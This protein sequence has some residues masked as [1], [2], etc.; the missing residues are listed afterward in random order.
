MTRILLKVAGVLAGLAVCVAL[1]VGL[2]LALAYPNL[3]DLD[4]LTDY[5][6]KVPLRVYTADNVLIGEFG[7]ER[8]NVVRIRDVPDVLKS[9]ILSAEDDGFYQHG[10]IDWTGVLRAA[11]TNAI[12]LQK[13]Q[14]ASTI[15]MQVARNFYLSSEKTYTRKLYEILLTFKIEANL[16]KD[17]I[18]ELYIN[19]IYLGQ[20]AYG[21]AS[22]ARIYFGK[23][24]AELT[25]SEAAMLAGIP[26][27]PS[28][29]NPVV[30]PTRATLR[31]QYVLRRM[32]ELGYLTD[33]EYRAALDDKMKI[34]PLGGEFAV[35][36]EYVAELA[37]QLVYDIYKEDTYT[38]G[39]NVYT[40]VN[41]A[42]QDAAY[43]ALRDGVM[44]YERRHGYRGPEAFVELPDG[45]DRDAEKLNE[46]VDDALTDH[47]DNDDLLA[48]VV[49]SADANKV[50]VARSAGEII[51][52]TGKGLRFAASGL[53][54]KAQPTQ[55]V[56]RGA[57][58]RIMKTGGE[59][60]ILQ[61]PAV[62][63]AFVSTDP[64]D[65][66]IR[67]M[68][69]G[70]D[71]QRG[72]FNRVTQAWR[73]PGSSFKPFIYAASL[74]RGLTPSTIISDAPFVLEA[75][76]TGS[77]RWE[78]KNYDGKNEAPM[79]MRQGLAKSKNLVSIRILQTIGPQYAQDYIT[80]FGFEAA[81]HPAYLTMA[82]GAGAVTPLQMA[83]AYSV[84]ANGGYRV[85]PFLIDKV[86]DGSGRVL[87][88]A[89]PAKA[90]DESV[91]AIDA[92][93]AYITDTMLRDVVRTG[94]ARAALALKRTDVGGKTGTTNNSV[95]GWFAGYTPQLVGIAWLG[96]DQPKSLGVRETGG[97]A[98]MP[99]WLAYMQK[100]LKGVPQQEQVMPPGIITANGDYYLSEFPPGQ[101]VATVGVAAPKEEDP[102]SRLI[103]GLGNLIGGNGSPSNA[104]RS[105]TQP[106]YL[107]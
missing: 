36:A 72:K 22:A 37:R 49:L 28:R 57:I 9:A 104:P 77:Q 95:D 44:D 41:K 2:A 68:V 73:Q 6:P 62:Q 94:T 81:R 3:P 50:R 71:F 21:F 43:E 46:A 17:Q 42:Q 19:Q 69:G 101:A 103:D 47:P 60:E 74:E 96:Y 75:A 40:T 1:L 105:A 34:K 90:G 93:T 76:A 106:D 107:P 10:G 15:T 30:N 53:N 7:E 66:A 97:G 18:L 65:G 59:W 33:P 25:A 39:L 58:V 31:Q 48:A 52:I 61:S 88:Q 24:V 67:A 20:R 27:A 56:R 11:F 87:M 92:R 80:R 29:Y 98:A 70:F 4:A 5:H 8:R 102:M 51:E 35:R 45:V 86:T 26:K 78:P 12:N 64:R 16:T 54:A 23:P 91:R 55:R 79:T 85:T 100:A 99:I 14:G 84:F 83:G 63:G 82:L 13:S 89:R 32:H 38:R